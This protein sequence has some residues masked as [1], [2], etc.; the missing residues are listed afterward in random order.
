M[1]GC[2]VES[3]FMPVARIDERGSRPG[4][5]VP[6]LI[7]SVEFVPLPFVERDVAGLKRRRRRC[8]VGSGPSTRAG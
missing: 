3:P 7:V 4:A 8:P 5:I 2:G 6:V 1:T